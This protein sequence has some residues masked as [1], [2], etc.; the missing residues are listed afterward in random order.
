MPTTLYW[1]PS[2]GSTRTAK[3]PRSPTFVLGICPEMLTEPLRL[4]ESSPVRTRGAVLILLGEAAG[5]LTFR[6]DG[7]LIGTKG[8][9]SDGE[10]SRIYGVVFSRSLESLKLGV[11]PGV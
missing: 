10:A 7:R 1:P 8:T 11:L 5:S 6:T 3:S 2:S 9:K 4:V